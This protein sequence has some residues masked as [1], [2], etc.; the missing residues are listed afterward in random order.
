MYLVNACEHFNSVSHNC[1]N[2]STWGPKS[3]IASADSHATH[4]LAHLGE[5]ERNLIFILI[6]GLLECLNSWCLSSD[7]LSHSVAFFHE[8]R[9]HYR[10]GSPPVLFWLHPE[11]VWQAHIH[12]GGLTRELTVHSLCCH[13]LFNLC[14]SFFCSLASPFIFLIP[15]TQS[16]YYFMTLILIFFRGPLRIPAWPY[17]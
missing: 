8:P 2:W 4:F 12:P 5:F 3:F 11:N 14:F 9:A 6:C 16:R 13:S 10:L 15:A 17:G 7:V 1:E